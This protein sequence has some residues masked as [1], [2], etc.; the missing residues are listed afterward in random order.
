MVQACSAA[1]AAGSHRRVGVGRWRSVKALQ[2]EA[3]AEQA[4]QALPR[5]I[6][7][8][9]R[10]S[11]SG[12]GVK[13]RDTVGTLSLSLDARVCFPA[14]IAATMPRCSSTSSSMCRHVASV[15][16]AMMS[17]TNEWCSISL[18]KPISPS[19]RCGCRR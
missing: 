5:G 4:E 2:A 8:G 11:R 9:A 1:S 6:C 3:E 13:K 17:R 10:T 14:S 7:G 18:M 19:V 12:S 16:D 15:L